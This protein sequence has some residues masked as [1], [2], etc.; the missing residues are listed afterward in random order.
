MRLLGIV[1]HKPP[2]EYEFGDISS[3]A[4]AAS[5]ASIAKTSAAL[6][7]LIGKSW[8]EYRFGDLTVATVRHIPKFIRRQR[9]TRSEAGMDA[10]MSSFFTQCAVL[11]ARCVERGAIGVEALEDCEPPLQLGG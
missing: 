3:A 9:R 5:S 10:I 1:I 8:D 6:Q 4:L 7:S 11:S 2:E